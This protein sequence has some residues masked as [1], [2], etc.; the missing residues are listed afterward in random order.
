MFTA[1]KIRNGSTYF[2]NHLSAN[3]YYAQGERVKG[4]W[5]GK[6]AEALGLSGEV[7]P[8]AFE[9]LRVNQR[10]GTGDRLTPRTKEM[11]QPTLAEAAQ[12]FRQKEGR[13]GTV[14]E[15]T[16]FR[17]S[18]KP[19]SNRVAFFDF[20]CSAQKSVSL[21][22]VLGEDKRLRTVHEE[23]SRIA[24]SELERFASRQRNTLVQR[25]SE[26][27]GNICAAAFT[28]D[29]SRALDPQLHTHFVIA[30]ATCDRAGKWYALN[31]C[32]MVRAVRY[33]GKVYQNEMARAVQ[34]LGYGI[35]LVRHNG[36]ITGFEIESVSDALCERFSKRREEIERQ[37]QKFE[38]KQGRKPTVKEVAL[39]TRETR[40]ATLKEIAT[41]EVLAF[42]RSQLSPE[43]CRQLQ[44]LRSHSEAQTVA[45]RAGQ[46]RQALR[47]SISHL[48]ERNSV[49]REH[50][51]LAE[52]LN[53][54]LGSL[55]LQRLKQAASNGEGGLVRLTD[56]PGNRLLSECCTRQGLR[57]EQQAVKY[58][59]D[60]RNTCPVLNSRFVPA[61]HLSEEQKEAVTSILST[62]D[63]VFSFRGV[64]GS[65]KTTTLREVQRGLRE[66]GHTVFAATPTASAARMLQS[67]GFAQATTVEDFLRN[68]EKRGGLRKAVV[69]CDE[70]GLKSNRQGGELLRLTHKYKMRVLLV[71]DVRQHVSVEAGDFLRVLEAHSKLG[72]CQVE[73]IHRQIPDDYRVAVTQMAAGNVRQ[74]LERLDQMNWIRE[75]QA[76]Y[77]EKAAT[78]FLRLT[79]QGR[80]LDRCLAVS[81]TWDENHRFTDS[82][83]RTLKERGVLPGEG[84]RL[85][86]HE[87]LRWTNQQ[88]ANWQRYEPGQVVA[89]AP[90]HDRPASSATVVR[91]EKGKVV[92]TLASREEMA[93][94][95]QRPDSFDVARS[96]Q[97]EVSSG[98]KILIRANDKRLGLTNGHVLT[99]S[100]IAP[101][102]ALQT[103]EGQGVPSEF[104]QWCHGYVVTSHKAQGWT[105]DHVVVAAEQL[106]SKG[107]YVA[108]S[109]G[110]KSCI[111]HTPDKARLIERLPE[112][113][114]RAALDALSEIRTSSASIVNRVRAWK[115]L[116]I[117]LAQ[118]FTAQVIQPSAAR[119]RIAH[120][121]KH[122]SQSL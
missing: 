7:R 13:T 85:E 61:A 10:P 48:F 51:I 68:A 52:A 78:D 98:D 121:Q 104:R 26:V 16:N 25:Q 116:S 101:D 20:Q 24:L 120:P 39:I 84:T 95:L 110:R 86:V 43:E 94:D 62:R 46:E 109:R 115:Q 41:S 57:L 97:I 72:R 56:S 80:H 28:H 81:F 83:R 11:R 18:M 14:H 8:E 66:A 75:G 38:E 99:V 59:D 69:I 31:E 17:L 67:E 106:T 111:V 27:T 36:E 50:E 32:E 113:N 33:A 100:S 60:T 103:K 74:G 76:D 44:S 63:R 114:R 107:A 73:E 6:G 89:F 2:A 30:N 77:L 29:A 122:L 42:Q 12:A 54:S 23:A 4:E 93:L 53:Q 87:S 102:G 55:D 45:V 49:L 105:A 79:D 71:G 117:D 3:D 34:K 1:A 64:A 91:V 90:G 21:L 108:C 88:K 92:V 15:V 82:I 47:A 9:A 58:V 35:R 119:M 37:I 5:V 118:R 96:R 19:V 22:A 112:G 70:A 65:G 40:P